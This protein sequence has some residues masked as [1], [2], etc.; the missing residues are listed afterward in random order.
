MIL[1]RENTFR[2]PLEGVGPEMAA[3]EA[4]AIWAHKS[5]SAFSVQSCTGFKIQRLAVA[6]HRLTFLVNQSQ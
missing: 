4:S 3:S 1:M 6:I 2:R 5:H